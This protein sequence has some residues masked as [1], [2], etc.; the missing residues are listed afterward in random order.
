MHVCA[1]MCACVCVRVH[2]SYCAVIRFY[3]MGNGYE[4]PMRKKAGGG[5]AD[6]L[7]SAADER[8]G[9]GALSGEE[10]DRV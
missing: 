10:S 4:F 1:A 9:A 3:S 8:G 7:L 6:R 2:T 5:E